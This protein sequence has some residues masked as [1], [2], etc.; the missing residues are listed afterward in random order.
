MSLKYI[1]LIFIG[2]IASITTTLAD[3]HGNAA[4]IESVIEATRS[5]NNAANSGSWEE[6]YSYIAL[7][8]TAFYEAGMLRET[9][10]TPQNFE[11]QIAR[12][13]ERS[14]NGMQR[15][16][17]IRHPEATIYGDTAIVTCYQHGRYRSSADADRED[18]LNRVTFVWRRT[19]DGWKLVHEHYSVMEK[20]F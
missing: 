1:P 9:K 20:D 10:E 13:T 15:G 8:C 6:H 14:K 18:I 7:G 17:F 2:A 5:Y 19:D 3:H 12:L 16:I 4:D 11:R